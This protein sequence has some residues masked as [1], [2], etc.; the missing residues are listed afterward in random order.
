MCYFIIISSDGMSMTRA[1]PLRALIASDAATAP[2]TLK[3][4]VEKSQVPVIS[5]APL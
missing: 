4:N 3:H 2:T 1:V 5:P